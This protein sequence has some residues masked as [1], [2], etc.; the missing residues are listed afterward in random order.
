MVT[1]KKKKKIKR[2]RILHFIFHHISPPP[3][4]NL[5]D[6]IALNLPKNLDKDFSF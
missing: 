6:I 5:A 3:L 4:H 2:N 1:Q